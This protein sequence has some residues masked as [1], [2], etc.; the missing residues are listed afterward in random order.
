MEYSVTFLLNYAGADV[1]Q[2]L[3]SIITIGLIISKFFYFHL[4]FI[5]APSVLPRTY[6]ELISSGLV[7]TFSFILPVP[8]F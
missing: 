3:L 2:L 1:N 4:L 6:L 7:L 8:N 5:K